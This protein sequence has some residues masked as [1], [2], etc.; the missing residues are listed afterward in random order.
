MK[1]LASL[2]CVAT[3]FCLPAFGFQTSPGQSSP[4]QESQDVPHQQP[5]TSNPDV[6][7]QRH[8]TPAPSTGS[9]QQQSDVPTQQPSTS[10]PDVGK[11][12]HA[13]GKRGKH[14]ATATASESSTQH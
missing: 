1:S 3:L 6:G 13:T 14:K 8:S 12:R 4:S 11:Q 5:S 2:T 10:N 9:S 7:K